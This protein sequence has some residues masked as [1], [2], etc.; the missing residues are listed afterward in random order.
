[1][2]RGDR[3]WQIPRPSS[4]TSQRYTDWV[5]CP[6]TADSTLG[7]RVFQ[8]ARVFSDSLISEDV[9]EEL[10]KIRVSHPVSKVSSSEAFREVGRKKFGV[11]SVSFKPQDVRSKTIRTSESPFGTAK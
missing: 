2:D 5:S 1:M 7:L 4:R 10:G 11:Q 6:K 8:D 9:M 3:R